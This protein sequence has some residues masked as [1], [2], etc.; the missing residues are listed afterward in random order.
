VLHGGPNTDEYITAWNGQTSG[1]PVAGLSMDLRSAAV[2]NDGWN[3]SDTLQ[4]VEAVQG[5][6][7]GDR[8][9]GTGRK[10]WFEGGGGNDVLR[11]QGGNDVLL[12]EDGRDALGGGDG[13]DVCNGGSGGSDTATSCEHI[14]GVP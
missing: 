8:I 3:A 9:T 7:F 14:A 1:L 12:G 2:A 4:S 11:G 10:E 6:R 13:V 5:T